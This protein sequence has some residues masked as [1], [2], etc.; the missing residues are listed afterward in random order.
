M[1]LIQYA[2]LDRHSLKEPLV[3]LKG[4][5]ALIL[6]NITRKWIEAKAPVHNK[7]FNVESRW[8]FRFIFNTIMPSPNH[9]QMNPSLDTLR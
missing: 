7:D 5:L 1:N 9:P 2:L 4:W 8:L 6:S 3:Y